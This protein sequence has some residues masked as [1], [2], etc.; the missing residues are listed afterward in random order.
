M[1][2]PTR[3]EALSDELRRLGSGSEG[4]RLSFRLVV[5]VLLRC[6]PLLRGVRRHLLAFF[7]IVLLLF[8]AILPLVAM[9]FD[10][11]WT[12][13]LQG[14]PLP[15]IQA[16]LLLLDPALVSG[17]DVLSEAARRSV[18]DHALVAAAVVLLAV[19]LPAAGALTYYYIW[20]T[21]RINQE[22][23]LQLH[24]RLQTLSLRFHAE[25]RVGD[26]IYRLH[27]DSAMVSDLIEAVFL[28]PV[29]HFGRHLIAAGVVFLFDPLAALIFLL[30]WPPALALGYWMSRRLRIGFRAARETNAA[31]TARIQ[32]ILEGIKVV[33]AY[34]TEPAAQRSF[35]AHSRAA[36]DAAF[37][38]RFL[39]CIFSVL[40]FGLVSVTTLAG[41][42]RMLEM[43]RLAEPVFAVALLIGFGFD[44]FT[45]GVFNLLK[46]ELGWGSGSFRIIYRMWARAQDMAIGLD[47]VF[48]LLDLEPE[49]QDAPDAVDLP[50]FQRDVTFRGVH[51][52]YGPDRPT[53]EDVGFTARA[54]SLTA[55]VGPTGS[56]KSTLMS[57]LLRL[58]DP[59]AGSIEIDGLDLR[60]VSLAS[61][62]SA[63]SIA[64]QENV[65]F[66]ATVR[67]NIRYAAP[68]ASD[69]AVREAARVAAADGFIQELPDGYDTLLGERGTKLSTGQRQRVSIA[70]AVLKDTP[71]LILD[72]PT[73]SLDAETELR[74]LR[75]L[76]AWGRDRAIF[77]VTHRLS[78]VR[79]A[80]RILVFHEGRLVEQG[81]HETLLERPGG[82]YRSLVHAEAPPAP[83]RMAAP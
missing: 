71:I 42:A 14:S 29:M 34:G 82:A 77:L 48:E 57:L 28:T 12:G 75:N 11:F 40:V 26:A 39:V 25:T 46:G 8:A 76:R 78:S 7:G 9:G 52:G 47:R 22:L 72:E 23:R 51:F 4:D 66:G 37:G 31:L 68:T 65:L 55:I 16:R 24:D 36:F 58:F 20:I 81:S 15:E 62:R 2:S 43:T 5:A 70:R 38:V 61:L 19:A 33:K 6:L 17:V 69:A 79:Q 74:V 1:A 73:A 59:D 83:Q 44:R 30:A 50:P 60:A 80:D 35:E 54:G 67:E 64:L 45:L 10:I 63:V 56:G 49:V 41:Y 32:E 21:Q 13:V 53:L 3:T 27:Q 18:R